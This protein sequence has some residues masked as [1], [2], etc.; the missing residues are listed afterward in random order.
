[1]AVEEFFTDEFIR[2]QELYVWTT[3]EDGNGDYIDIIAEDDPKIIRQLLKS[4]FS[5]YGEARIVVE[6]GNYQDKQQLFL[7]HIDTGFELDP[8]YRDLTLKNLHYLW[9]K[10]VYLACKEKDENKIFSFDYESRKTG[11]PNIH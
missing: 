1:M 11:K 9:G 7:R 6:D 4:M 5:S 3:I 10:R 8:A 2:E